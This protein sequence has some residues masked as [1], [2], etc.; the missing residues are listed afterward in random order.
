MNSGV[1]PVNIIGATN[2]DDTAILSLQSD[3]K[4][5]FQSHS[6]SWPSGTKE[7]M[8]IDIANDKVGIN[9]SSPDVDLHINGQLKIVDG[10]Q[11]N[12]KVLTSDANGLASWKTPSSGGGSNMPVGS[13]IQFAGDTAPD[14]WL[15]CDGTYH[16]Q[17]VYRELYQVI[18]NTYDKDSQSGKFAVPDIRGRVPVGKHSTGTFNS[19]NKKG[20]V[21]SHTLTKDQVPF[22][23][24]SHTMDLDNKFKYPDGT[25]S[26]WP[27]SAH[28]H[29]IGQF[30]TPESTGQWSDPH[31][32]V[33]HDGTVDDHKFVINGHTSKKINFKRKDPGTGNILKG[34]EPG[35]PQP[36]FKHH[37]YDRNWSQY[38]NRAQQHVPTTGRFESSTQ[39]NLVGI[40]VPDG[41]HVHTLSNGTDTAVGGGTS[42]T[43]HTNVQPYIVLN[44]IIYYG[45]KSEVSHEDNIRGDN[46]YIGT[47]PPDEFRGDG[48]DIIDSDNHFQ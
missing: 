18:S 42:A 2:D 36:A 7:T 48:D 30:H 17:D 10:T 44:Y 12:N 38:F 47:P 3:S 23:E 46:D 21:E 9:Q 31:S 37:S 4:I 11:G 41:E 1:N 39:A 29:T 5:T 34:S 26:V 20:G 22:L 24:H 33:I 13:I 25:D 43:S 19:L 14:G 28:W 16:R 35:G 8:T 15:M 40:P 45:T 27:E 32:Q 6:I